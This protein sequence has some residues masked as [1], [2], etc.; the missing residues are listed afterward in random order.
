[1]KD[2]VKAEPVVTAAAV[3]LAI[4]ATGFAVALGAPVSPELAAAIE[5]LTSALMV[6]VFVVVRLFVTPNPKVIEREQDGHV[7]AGGGNDLHP[8]DTH[9]REIGETVAGD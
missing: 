6:A 8:A 7:L 4:A 3:G 2:L 1:M 9:I 5:A